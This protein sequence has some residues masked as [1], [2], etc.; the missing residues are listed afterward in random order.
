[1]ADGDLRGGKDAGG[2]V[3]PKRARSLGAAAA[4]DVGGAPATTITAGD[5]DAL[6]FLLEGLS[7]SP[8]KKVKR[9]SG[10]L[11]DATGED[12]KVL[13]E[14]LSDHGGNAVTSTWPKPSTRRQ[15]LTFGASWDNRSD[16]DFLNRDANPAGADI[17]LPNVGNGSK[18]VGSGGTTRLTWRLEHVVN[19]AGW[20]WS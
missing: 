20:A 17:A 11:L 14:L 1:M 18:G 9:S 6:Q 5:S 2:G 19:V 12:G 3:S 15:V 13:P 8:I 4:A 10:D 16:V 7:P